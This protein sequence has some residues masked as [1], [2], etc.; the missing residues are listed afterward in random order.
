M[1]LLILVVVMYCCSSQT[2]ASECP[3]NLVA[4]KVPSTAS[5]WKNGRFHVIWLSIITAVLE[6]IKGVPDREP[7][8]ATAC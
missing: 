3:E 6:P 7:I 4:V 8:L 5:G 2:L 1:G